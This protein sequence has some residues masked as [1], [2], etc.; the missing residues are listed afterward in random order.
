MSDIPD[1]LRDQVVL[2]DGNRCE[3]CGLSQSGIDW[4]R[5]ADPELGRTGCRLAGVTA[6]R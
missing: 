2:R 3:Y 1:F 6:W 4:R 5:L